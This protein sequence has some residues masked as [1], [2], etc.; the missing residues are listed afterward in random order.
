MVVK[1]INSYYYFLCDQDYNIKYA[2]TN[3]AIKWFKWL[4]FVENSIIID[5]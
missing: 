2:D 3:G 4:N 5:G 1:L